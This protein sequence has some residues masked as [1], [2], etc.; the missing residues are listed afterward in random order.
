MQE[1]SVAS[2]AANSNSAASNCSQKTGSQQQL[3]LLAQCAN[4]GAHQLAASQPVGPS[5]GATLVERVRLSQ[6]PQVAAGQAKIVHN[7]ISAAHR[8]ELVKRMSS[9]DHLL[10]SS[11]RLEQRPRRKLMASMNE[12]NSAS[13]SSSLEQHRCNLNESISSLAYESLMNTSHEQTPCNRAN[14]S[15]DQQTASSNQNQPKSCDAMLWNQSVYSIDYCSECCPNSYCH[16]SCPAC[17]DSQLD[18]S[19][20]CGHQANSE[21]QLNHPQTTTTTQ[22]PPNPTTT[23]QQ[24]PTAAASNNNKPAGSDYESAMFDSPLINQDD[25]RKP[26]ADCSSW[27][28]SA[29][30][31]PHQRLDTDRA[32]SYYF[33]S[34]P[35]SVLASASNQQTHLASRDDNELSAELGK[36]QQQMEMRSMC[37]D[38]SQ[39]CSSNAK[40]K[41]RRATNDHHLQPSSSASNSSSSTSSSC[42]PPMDALNKNP[43]RSKSSVGGSQVAPLAFALQAAA[44]SAL[45]PCAP[46]SASKPT[47]TTTSIKQDKSS[48]SSK[49]RDNASSATSEQQSAT[50]DCSAQDAVQSSLPDSSRASAKTRRRTSLE[51]ASSG[52]QVNRRLQQQ[53]QTSGSSSRSHQDDYEYTV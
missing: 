21:Q 45:G 27:S 20:I 26:A 13:S 53:Q 42:S 4:C 31:R 43:T 32:S 9:D 48:D 25:S 34:S 39:S 22:Q 3:T 1:S 12:L 11:T 51:Q 49:R 5:T 24:Q 6:Q 23:T 2:A 52:S 33:K 19:A 16:C 8:V 30:S 14:Q 36:C 44:S 37:A 46:S 40:L 18:S 38:Q 28:T 17:L 10:V 47:T 7:K 35:S 50:V 41:L 29:T 15:A